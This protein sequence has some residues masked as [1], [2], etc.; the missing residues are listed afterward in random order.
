MLLKI[1]LVTICLVLIAYLSKQLYM[2]N[3]RLRETAQEDR[4]RQLV[5]WNAPASRR[6]SKPRSRLSK[7]LDI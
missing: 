1:L 3:A 4:R 7:M 2:L 6:R 5:D